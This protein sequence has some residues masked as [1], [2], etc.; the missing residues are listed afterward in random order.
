MGI[1]ALIWYDDALNARQLVITAVILLALV[2]TIDLIAPPIPAPEPWRGWLRPAN[3]PTPHN[4]CDNPE[5]PPANFPLP[6]NY[7]TVIVGNYAFGVTKQ[8]IDK[9]NGTFAPFTACN[10]EPLTI[11][12][13]DN[14][15]SINA[16]LADLSGNSVGRIIN[17]GYNVPRNGEILKP[18]HSGDLS[19][20]WVHAKDGTEVL[21]VHFLNQHAI[22]IRGIFSCGQD[23]AV[24]V[25]NNGIFAKNGIRFS[26]G[27]VCLEDSIININ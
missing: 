15:I 12:L 13:K 22:R 19:T 16:A 8:L 10:T 7:M 14:E 24:R 2:L 9:R 18:E 26:G 27:L 21:F 3:D 5:R 23:R 25:S 11:T 20:I 17:N 6:K 4:P 1:F